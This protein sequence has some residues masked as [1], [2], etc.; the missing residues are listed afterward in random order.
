L[1]ELLHLLPD[2]GLLFVDFAQVLDSA[3][4]ADGFA[5]IRLDTQQ[6]LKFGIHYNYLAQ[7]WGH[8]NGGGLL[9]LGHAGIGVLR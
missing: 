1:N 2:F 7:R 4:R 6:H 3:R 9:P 5:T 8:H